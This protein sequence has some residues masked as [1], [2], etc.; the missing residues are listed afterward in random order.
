MSKEV[1]VET[2]PNEVVEMEREVSWIDPHIIKA[3]EN[4]RYKLLEYRVQEMKE[5]II[6]KGGVMQPI[7]IAPLDEVEG[8]Y[9]YL[10]T[11]GHYRLAG[12]L[13]AWEDGYEFQMPCFI[14]EK[15][16]P[17]TRFKRQLTENITRDDL[18]PIDKA[19]AIK[20]ALE[21]GLSKQEIRHLFPISG[22]RKGLKS[23][24]ASNS[25]I[26]MTLS[27]LD[28]SKKIQTYIHEGVIGVADAYWLTKQSP[29]KRDKAVETALTNRLSEI[30][31]ADDDE[32]KYLEAEKKKVEAQ[33]KAQASVKSLEEAKVKAEKA[34]ADLKAKASKKAEYFLVKA[35]A[36]TPE[37][38]EVAAAALATA[39][40][41]AKQAEKEM[42]AARREVSKL[43]E[44]AA[45]QIADAE[46]RQL[47]LNA[48][49]NAAKANKIPA[50]KV[51][52]Q[53][54][55]SATAEI[56]NTPNNEGVPIT[57]AAGRKALKEIGM[58]KDHPKVSAIV[59]AVD[60]MFGGQMTGKELMHTLGVITGEKMEKVTK[61]S[62]K[63]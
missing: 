7:E 28:L 11:F 36:Q 31:E 37:E 48:A 44:K 55:K 61:K 26:N 6:E 25:F 33:D 58:D 13:A 40:A 42:T 24:D 14:T 43:E 57:L 52:L 50:A 22:G 16:D 45:K 18:T 34:I 20:Q 23:Q 62:P 63:E 19:R 1:E 17:V 47:K 29:D 2:A 53:V 60:Q 30:S 21:L 38:K 10:V 56:K 54:K 35:E 12:I 41:E 3:D 32:S 8:S 39:E 27:F 51:P 4:I 46:A 9:E 5:S 59:K 15:L 49:K